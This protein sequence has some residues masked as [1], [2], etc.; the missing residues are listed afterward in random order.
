[1]SLTPH[2]LAL[3]HARAMLKLNDEPF[4]ATAS[5]DMA[6]SLR[7]GVSSYYAPLHLQRTMEAMRAAYP[8]VLVEVAKG[9]SCQLVVPQLREGAFDL[10]VISGG[11][12]PP[13]W[14]LTEV[15]CGPLQWITSAIQ[16]AHRRD[17][18]PL[19]LWPSNCP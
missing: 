5:S 8:G 18:L 2:G 13:D 11:V 1:M 7:M 9:K 14:P 3:E 17:P 12:E 10:I 19:R 6:R 15:C 4:G 16:D